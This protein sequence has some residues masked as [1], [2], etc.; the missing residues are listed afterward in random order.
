VRQQVPVKTASGDKQGRTANDGQHVESPILNGTLSEGFQFAC[1][2]LFGLG[3]VKRTAKIHP[4]Q[5]TT[6]K[7]D[8][9]TG[10]L[11]IG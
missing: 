7:S 10:K 5:R 1:F 11:A 3:S 2:A 4:N 6:K 8:S 9:E